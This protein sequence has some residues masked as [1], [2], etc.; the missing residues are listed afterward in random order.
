MFHG[1]TPT[2]DLFAMSWLLLKECRITRNVNGRSRKLDIPHDMPLLSTLRDVLSMTGTKVWLRHAT[3]RCM[4]DSLRRRS[5]AAIGNR[6]EGI[7]RH[8][9][10]ME[11]VGHCWFNAG[12]GGT[13][14]Q[15]VKKQGR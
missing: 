15:R 2:S 10:L 9:R 11:T 1:S 6:S 4:H 14:K 13:K 8:H 3:L 7:D 5:L 12:S